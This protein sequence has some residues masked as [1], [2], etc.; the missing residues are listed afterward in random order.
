MFE[1]S[2]GGHPLG[3]AEKRKSSEMEAEKFGAWKKMVTDA[4]NV[5]LTYEVG[6]EDLVREGYAEHYPNVVEWNFFAPL[7]K[8]LKEICSDDI[9]KQAF[10]KSFK[11]VKI[12]GSGKWSGLEVKISGDTIFLDADPSYNRTQDTI[13]SDAEQIRKAIEAKL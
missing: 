8:A 2:T 3:L 5:E 1:T 9:G 12:T 7:A 4:C 6:W 10:K 13:F 11:K